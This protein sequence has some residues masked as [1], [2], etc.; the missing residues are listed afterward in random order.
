MTVRDKILEYLEQNKGEYISGEQLA[1]ELGVSR[2]AVWKAVKKLS[3]EEFLI[4]A[5]PNKGY[6]LKTSTDVL[7]KNGIETYLDAGLA[8]NVEVYKTIDSTN[9]AMKKRVDEPEGL[10][11]VSMEQTA[12]MGR[13]GRRFESPASTG[14][15]FSILLKP[16]ISNTEVTLLTAIAGVAVCEAIEKY[17]DKKPKIKWV[18]DVFIDE[19]K[20]C[21]TLTQAG[22]SLE[23]LKPEYVIVGTG[24]NLYEPKNGFGAE[25][26]DIAG[27]VLDEQI[28]DIKNKLLA[29]V[30]NR[31][32]YYY[33]NFSKKEFIGEYKKRSMVIGKDV[34]VVSPN[35]SV[36]ASVLDIDDECRLI[37]R[38]EDGRE[39]AV[40]TGEISIRLK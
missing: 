24:I 10:I 9:L 28:G 27:H 38:Y 26:K 23:D 21:G 18:N 13:L 40:S 14:I 4:D 16:D 22:F 31:Y 7:S 17:L 11:I 25:L 3:E 5:V 39:E 36:N 37:V 12:G 20:V 19:K 15:Y 29:E 8:L 35:D 32:F 30:L 6:M 34:M 33:H 2:T 1:K